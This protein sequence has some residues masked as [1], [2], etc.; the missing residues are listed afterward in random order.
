LLRLAT[1]VK[2]Q[3]D[4]SARLKTARCSEKKKPGPDINLAGNVIDAKQIKDWLEHAMY[5]HMVDMIMF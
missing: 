4:T 2:K 5:G 1:F 3:V